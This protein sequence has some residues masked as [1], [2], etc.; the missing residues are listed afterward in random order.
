MI[1]WLSIA[2]QVVRYKMNAA[3]SRRTEQTLPSGLVLALYAA[4]G[5]TLLSGSV[6]M[7]LALHLWLQTL[8]SPSLAALTTSVISFLL[9]ALILVCICWG[10]KRQKRNKTETALAGASDSVDSVLKSF[11]DEIGDSVKDYPKSAIVLALVAGA[12]AGKNI[13]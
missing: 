3:P 12:L 6:F 7:L 13:L 8:Y 9:A 5:L 11:G 2:E 4:A 10:K 1:P